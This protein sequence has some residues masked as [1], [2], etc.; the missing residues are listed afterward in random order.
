MIGQRFA[1]VDVETTGGY[2]AGNHITEIGVAIT[3]C[4]EMVVTWNTRKFTKHCISNVG[5]S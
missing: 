3:T 5:V 2:A 1:V 4:G